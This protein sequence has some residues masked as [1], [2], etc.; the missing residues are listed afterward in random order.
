M[1]FLALFLFFVT[2]TCNANTLWSKTGH[3]VTGHIAQKHLSRKAKKAVANLLDGHSLAFASTF[4]DEIKADRSFSKY[5]A[6]HYVNY[7]MNMRY[8]DSEKSEYG[9][10]V[11]GIEKCKAVLQDENS[12]HKDKVFHLKL[13]IHLIG[14]LHQPMHVGRGS[15]R[16][17]NDIQLQWFDEGTNL[18]RLW[19]S[20]LINA[21]GM[22]YYE[23]GDELVQSV[24]KKEKRT[25]QAGTLYDWV[26]ESHVLAAEVYQSVEVG[27]KLRYQYA[28]TYN[29]LLFEQLQKGGFRLAKVL[30]E[31]FG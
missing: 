29:D 13:L 22:T 1:R 12:T 27:E 6:W 2:I 19:D 5:S 16:G 26:H 3:R 14:D 25:I 15:D 7:P 11:M 17:G 30:N 4:A 28:Y 8:E 23:L 21:Y 24:T 10:V 31:I 18:H 20:N 9:D